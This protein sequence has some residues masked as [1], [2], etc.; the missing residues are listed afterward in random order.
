MRLERRTAASR[1]ALVVAPLAA[2]AV[3]LLICALLVAWAG[4]PVGRTYLLLLEG[5]FG[6]RF[7]LTETL[8]RATPL[9]LTGLAVAVAFRARL[10][11]IGAEGP[12]LCRRAGRGRRRRAARRR[13]L[14]AAGRRA[15]R[16][17]DPG[18]DGRRRR[19]AAGA[20]L[21]QDAAVGR[22]GGHHAAAQLHRAAVRL[23]DAGR[24]DEG[25]DRARLAAVGGDQAGARIR[26]PAREVA[27]AHRLPVGDRGGAAAAVAQPRH[28]ARLRDAGGRQQSA[29]GRVSSAC[30][31]ATWCSRPRSSP[32]R[33]PGSPAPPRSRAGPAT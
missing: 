19:A 23:G 15:L 27:A 25:S 18:R 2:I 13:G 28:R 6:S 1:T 16:P 14:R 22:R 4:A 26:P 10:F 5:G 3:T 17:D 20:G 30:R 31:S 12:V 21:A 32:A 8:T 29:G 7:A 9:I 11:N 33:S 24:A